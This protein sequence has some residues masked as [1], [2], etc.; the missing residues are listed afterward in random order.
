M[1]Q[2]LIDAVHQVLRE[3]LVPELRML[4]E[5]LDKAQ[6]RVQQSVD[7]LTQKMESVHQELAA[8]R[9]DLAQLRKELQAA[10]DGGLVLP[11]PSRLIH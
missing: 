1:D 10:R 8:T 9:A 11:P 7:T 3:D 5:R 6:R 4:A 2:E